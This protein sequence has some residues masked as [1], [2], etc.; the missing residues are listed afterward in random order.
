MENR[1]V[2]FFGFIGLLIIATMIP[3][4]Y[5]SQPTMTSESVARNSYSKGSA[6]IALSNEQIKVC[7]EVRKKL[8]QRLNKCGA[9]EKC[10]RKVQTD[11]DIHNER[12]SR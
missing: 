8:I 7:E 6:V 9:D 4:G 2:L 5:A 11:I 3:Q 12:C 1:F 10:R